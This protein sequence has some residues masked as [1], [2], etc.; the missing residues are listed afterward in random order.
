MVD[1]H[2]PARPVSP[3]L[4]ATLA[5]AAALVLVTGLQ[6]VAAST[7]T[8]DWFAWT[9]QPPLTATFVGAA[10]LAAFAFLALSAR[11]RDWANARSAVVAASVF[12]P[13]MFAATLLHL[14]RF[15]LG[16]GSATGRAAGWGWLCLYVAVL[17]AVP[18]GVAHQL[19]RTH[20]VDPPRAERLPRALRALLLLEGAALAGLG[21]ALF[22]APLDAAT[23]W[24]WA[25][26]PL[27]GR[28]VGAWLAAVGA[29]LVA[30]ARESDRRRLRALFVFLAL[31]G[32]LEL[33]ALARHPGTPDWDGPATWGYAAAVVVLVATGLAGLR[34][35]ARP[36]R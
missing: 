35:R 14:D 24:P 10:Y 15:H 9:I 8:E 5:F 21:V 18:L 4:R 26:T 30:G 7:A 29:A 13:L 6:L 23:A 2:A 36:A 31:G 17:V 25:L 27:T 20:G 11:E 32:T 19:G 34:G 28:T 16:A 22:A 1:T 33:L 12:V 3:W